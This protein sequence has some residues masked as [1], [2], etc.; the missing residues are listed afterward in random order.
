[1]TDDGK[2]VRENWEVEELACVEQLQGG[3]SLLAWTCPPLEPSHGPGRQQNVS[4]SNGNCSGSNSS[5][6][7]QLQVA[8]KGDGSHHQLLIFYSTC[9]LVGSLFTFTILVIVSSILVQVSIGGLIVTFLV[10]SILPMFHTL[11]GHVVRMNLT[12]M[13]LFNIS[14]LVIFQATNHLPMVVCTILGFFTYFCSL[15]MFS[16]MTGT[17]ATIITV[18]QSLQSS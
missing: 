4:L 6:D 14:L 13:I 2:L 18:S 9:I 8:A 10:Y 12:S 7:Q 11:H 5:M 16:W 15:A 1:M 3:E 17:L